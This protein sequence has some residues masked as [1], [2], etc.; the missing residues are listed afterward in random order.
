MNF[1]GLDGDRVVQL[2]GIVMVMAL[3]ANGSAF[4]SLS[5]RKRALY[6]AIWACVFGLGT[7]FL[8]WL[9]S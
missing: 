6:A 2:L 3:L 1:G 7:V 8:S 5:W 4:R 9:A